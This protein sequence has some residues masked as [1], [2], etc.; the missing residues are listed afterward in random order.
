MCVNDGKRA[1]NTISFA[2][3]TVL[4]VENESDLQKLVNVFDSVRK[5]RKLKLNINKNKVMVV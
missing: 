4:I 3:D 2:D 1:L 5:R